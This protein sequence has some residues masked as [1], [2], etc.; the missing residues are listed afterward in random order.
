MTLKPKSTTKN[1]KALLYKRFTRIEGS[2]SLRSVYLTTDGLYWSFDNQK[3]AFSQ[4]SDNYIGQDISVIPVGDDTILQYMGTLFRYL[5]DW[6]IVTEHDDEITLLSAK[7]NNIA[8]YQTDK[9]YYVGSFDYMVRG[10]ESETIT[11]HLKG[12]V[13][14]LVS[15]NI[16]HFN[17]HISLR[18]D[19]LVVIDG[20][21]FS[22][23]APERVFKR[24]PKKFGV[25]FA[26]LNSIL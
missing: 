16:K 25:Y 5:G 15:L 19:D 12:N 23:E 10:T 20:R 7:F 6:K 17:D 2:L 11:Q 22:V 3:L 9:Y 14:P 24:Q 8:K 1:P 26:T 21:L 18:E 4:V 13:M